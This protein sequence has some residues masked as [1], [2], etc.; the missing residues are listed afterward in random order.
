LDRTLKS[1]RRRREA[2]QTF[3]RHGTRQPPNVPQDEPVIAGTP[4]HVPEDGSVSGPLDTTTPDHG[5]QCCNPHN[6]FVSE[7]IGRLDTVCSD[8]QSLDGEPIQCRTR[9]NVNRAPIVCRRLAI[10]MEHPAPAADRPPPLPVPDHGPRPRLLDQ[11]PR[12]PG[13]TVLL[14]RALRLSLTGRGLLIWHPR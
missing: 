6:G 14:P 11:Q 8:A 10:L 1:H 2:E 7:P 9:L 3:P 12:G 5:R 4:A 13:D